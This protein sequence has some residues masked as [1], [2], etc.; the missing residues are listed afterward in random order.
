MASL[1]LRNIVK[2]YGVGPK[3]NQVIHGVNAEVKD[4][5]F[6]VIVGPSGCGKSTLLRMVAGLEEI[7]GGELRIGDRVVNNLEPAQRDIAMVFQNYALYPHMTNFENMAY[8]LKIAK[9]PKEEIQR[10][11]DKAAKILELSHL[12][13]RKPREL[14]GGQRQRVAM[15]RAIVRQPQV[16]LFDEPL[17]NLDAK[18]RAQTRLEIQKLHRELGITSLFVTHD[19]VEAMTLAQRMIVMNAGNMEQFGTPEEV[20][21]TPATTFVA[22]FIGSPPMNLLK[23]A[24]GAKSGTILGIRPEHLD[25]GSEGWAVTV[26]TVELLGAERL[27]YGR[28]NGEQ[29]IVRVEEGTHAPLPD[30]VIHVLPR[31]DRLHAFD[32]TTGQ[33][34]AP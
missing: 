14:S 8:G 19:Q 13:E 31:P 33:R 20:Y 28:I 12:L 16:F 32:A 15:G 26:E 10:R 4:G 11:V 34:I 18:L 22:S 24:P 5:E 3:A 1:S 27:I 29:I 23:N 17:S 2:R 25:V 9:V 6:V 30:A 7:S 21:H